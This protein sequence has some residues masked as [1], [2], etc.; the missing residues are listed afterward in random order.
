[1]TA[2]VLVGFRTM[3]PDE[4]T[5]A[6]MSLNPERAVFRPARVEICRAG[7]EGEGVRGVGAD[8]DRQRRARGDGR[9]RRVVVV[10]V[11]GGVETERAADSAADGD[12]TGGAGQFDVAGIGTAGRSS[13]GDGAVNVV[14][15]GV[16]RRRERG[17]VGERVVGGAGAAGDIIEGRGVAGA[18]GHRQRA[19][20]GSG[21][22]LVITA[23]GGA[24]DGKVLRHV[25]TRQDDVAGSVHRRARAGHAA[26]A[27][28]AVEDGRQAGGV[29]EGIGGVA[30][31]EGGGDGATGPQCE[32]Q[33]VACRQA[34]AERRGIDPDVRLRRG[35]E[36]AEGA[37]DGRAAGRQRRVGANCAGAGCR[38]IAH[39]ARCRLL[40]LLRGRQRLLEQ[41]R[42]AGEA[43]GGR[44]DRLRALSDL[45]EQCA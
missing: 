6:V 34:T 12:R 9:E 22:V 37:G 31:A 42:Q 21:G 15:G 13:R 11:R 14:R 1:M 40:R 36:T 20:G 3:L 41:A 28:G 35:G 43:V 38:G 25:V 45:V 5:D 39:S 32:G 8:L 29:R 2:S 4:L 19:A 16:D 26:A 33:R 30:R 10:V 18:V 44:I 27:L 23:C 17:G 7:A 24:A